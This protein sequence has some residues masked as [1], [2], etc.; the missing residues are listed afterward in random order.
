MA[1]VTSTTRV[2]LEKRTWNRNPFRVAVFTPETTRHQVLI[3]MCHSD[4]VLIVMCPSDAEMTFSLLMRYASFDQ[5]QN[6]PVA[7]GK[8]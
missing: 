1:E 3:A 5:L 6:R 2:L 7:N 4:Q 8:F